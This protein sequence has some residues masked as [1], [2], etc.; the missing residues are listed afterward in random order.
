MWQQENNSSKKSC[1]DISGSSSSYTK[2]KVQYT[3]TYPKRR[4]WEKEVETNGESVIETPWKCVE[5]WDVPLDIKVTSVEMQENIVALAIE[6]SLLEI[7]KTCYDKVI[8]LL[9]QDYNCQPS[10][11]YEHPEYLKRIL[12]EYYGKASKTIIDS[13]YGKLWDYATNQDINKFMNRINS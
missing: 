13:I 8:E 12:S 2:R 3:E 11:C 7:S 1:V 9:Y 5:E 4:L 10:D 6:E